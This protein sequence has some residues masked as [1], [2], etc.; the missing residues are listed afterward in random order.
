MR[1]SVLR[2]VR[3]VLCAI[4][5]GSSS[6]F[7][8]VPSSFADV[9]APSAATH[10][11]RGVVRSFGKERR[12]VNIAHDEIP[13]YMNAMTMAFTPR[14]PSQLDGIEA[15]DVVVVRFTDEGHVHR[16]D[17]IQKVRP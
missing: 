5:V 12:Y 9:P 8:G 6:L 10:E 15:D 16:I 2:I 3:V 1:S 7:G 14:E 4:A 17:A 13:G 11:A